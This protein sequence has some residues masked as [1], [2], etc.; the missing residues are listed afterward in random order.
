MRHHIGIVITGLFLL[1]AIPARASVEFVETP[2]P[3]SHSARQT[4]DCGYLV[5]PENYDNPESATIRLAVAIF[6]HPAG[7]PE[8]DPILYL[9]GGPGGSALEFIQFTFPQRYEPLFATNRDMIVF[10]QRGIGL[11]DPA[12]D[13]PAAQALDLDLL[14]FDTQEQP[15]TRRAAEALFVGQLKACM[16]ALSEQHDLS[17]YNSA[18]SARD[19]ESL[20][21]VLGYEQIN[22]WGISYG[23]RLALTAM[24]DYP[25][26]IRSVVLDSV[27]PLDVNLLTD[28]P[29]SQ[30][31]AFNALFDACAADSACDSAFPDLRDVFWQ[32]VDDLNANPARVNAVNPLTGEIYPDVVLDG[33][34]FLNS[35]T[36]L[37]YDTSMI[38]A[39]PQLI[40][41]TNL[42]DFSA[43]DL[44]I[45]RFIAQQPVISDGMHIAVQCQEELFFAQRGAIRAAYDANPQLRVYIDTGYEVESPFEICAAA[46]AGTPLS[47]ANDPVYS[48]IP[49]LITAGHFDPIT[50]PEWGQRVSERLSNSRY[51]EFPDSGH[52]RTAS[53][54]CPQA[55]IIAF[56]ID[57]LAD[58]DTSCVTSMQ[59]DFTGT[60]AAPLESLPVLLR[61]E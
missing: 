32:T 12:L 41:Q 8:P 40:M 53:L 18:A 43:Y 15:L 60:Q 26:G 24:R 5:V 22:L 14:D 11:S 29:F 3:F 38:P 31:R 6:R 61:G 7:H 48:D 35:I 20:R 47:I 27:Y 25:G 13:C 54:G 36:R 30:M 59:L 28:S 4:V 46:D 39:L 1:I 19:I 44:I 45:G 37:L 23:T 21:L 55:L 51:I 9:E 52:G 49:T 50:P 56:F 33:T 57:P 17:Q 58:L 34:A 42:G 16:E 10:D 2:C